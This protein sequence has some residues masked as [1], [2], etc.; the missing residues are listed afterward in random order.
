MNKLNF[1]YNGKNILGI[2]RDLTDAGLAEVAL[3][4]AETH[5]EVFAAT[6][7]GEQF[8]PTPNVAPSIPRGDVEIT[9][10]D[11]RYF[12]SHSDLNV[13]EEMQDKVRAVKYLRE[14]YSLSLKEAKDLTEWLARNGYV[15]KPHWYENWEQAKERSLSELL[16][17]QF[18]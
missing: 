12:V 3:K 1:M 2:A 5:P 10:K 9:Q 13:L 15:N 11:L 17:N 7:L 6:L 14:A 18:N 4:I 8:V 16:R